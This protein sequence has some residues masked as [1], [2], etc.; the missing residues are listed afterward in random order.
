MGEVHGGT[1]G[2][3]GGLEGPIG[4][5]KGQ[6]EVKGGGQGCTRG[7]PES[8][9]VPGGGAARCAEGAGGRS[10]CKTLEQ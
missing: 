5:G 3:I 6:G 2:A 7:G 10:G 4:P 9:D 1:G 8:T